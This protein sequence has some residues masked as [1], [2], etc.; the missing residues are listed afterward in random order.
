MKG[1][2]GN[3]LISIGN[4]SRELMSVA[5]HINMITHYLLFSNIFDQVTS[6]VVGVVS[7]SHR[8]PLCLDP[9]RKDWLHL[10]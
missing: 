1:D 6:L 3:F 7:Q 9:Q 10:R 4:F 5:I 2:N 8:H